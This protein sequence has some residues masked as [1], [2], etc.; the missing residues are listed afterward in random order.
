MKATITARTRSARTASTITLALACASLASACSGEYPLGSASSSLDLAAAGAPRNEP[1]ALD[2]SV[3]AVLPPHSFSIGVRQSTL[4][5]TLAAVGDLDGDGFGDTAESGSDDATGAS[6]VHIRYGGPRPRDMIEALA[7]DRDGGYLAV[8]PGQGATYYAVAAAGDVDG[9]GFDDLLLKSNECIVL[10]PEGASGAYLVYGGPERV[11]GTLPLESVSSHF[12]PP[13][14]PGKQLDSVSACGSAGRAFGA[15]DIDG[16]GL[17]DIVVAFGPQINSDDSVSYAGGEGVYIHYGS[18]ERFPAEVPLEGAVFRASETSVAAF[19]VGDVTGDGLADLYL[20]P[21]FVIDY[22]DPGFLLVGR[23]ERW[24]GS[25]DLPAV[26]TTLPGV[27]IDSSDKLHGPRDIDGDGIDDLIFWSDDPTSMSAHLF[28]GG[29]G[30]FAGGFDFADADAVF[31]LG[32][33][34]GSVS[35]PGDLDGDGDD[36]LL[37]QFFVS[38]ELPSPMDVALLSGSRD[39]LAGDIVFAEETVVAQSPSGRFPAETGRYL[40][41]T[42]PAGDLDGDGAEDLFTLSELRYDVTESSYNASDPQLH[43]VYGTKAAASDELR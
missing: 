14:Y 13:T 29:P 2:G 36:D 38:P 40:T 10:D 23:T 32:A 24:S 16:D 7:F 18:A 42:I 34:T 17:D 4:P 1:A 6:W 21:E 8:T 28:Y 39:R 15:G 31:Q 5:G 19:A 3:S 12:L 11:E 43:V 41:Y 26:A 25:L 35:S 27:W 9:D 20:G 33:R 37:D 22:G 30:L